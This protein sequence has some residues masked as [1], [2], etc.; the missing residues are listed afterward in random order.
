MTTKTALDLPK[1][2][3]YETT[4]NVFSDG[5]SVA[6]QKFYNNGELITMIEI[7]YTSEPPFKKIPYKFILWQYTDGVNIETTSL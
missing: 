7:Y 2:D 5:T 1:F 3:F 6:Y 4:S